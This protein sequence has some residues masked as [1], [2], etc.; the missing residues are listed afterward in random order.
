LKE[1]YGIRKINKSILPK[2]DGS[3]DLNECDIR[4]K[5]NHKEWQ[6]EASTFNHFTKDFAVC[7]KACQGGS[8]SLT[9]SAIPYNLEAQN[10][11]VLY[12]DVVKLADTP[13]LG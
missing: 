13:D 3:D 1:I 11:K 2:L 9:I 8:H 12:G 7:D 6:L 10:L 4:K 5:Q